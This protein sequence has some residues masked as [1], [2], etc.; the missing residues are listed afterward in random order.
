[1]Y[2]LAPFLY[3][4]RKK[5]WQQI[6]SYEYVSFFEQNDQIAPSKIFFQKNH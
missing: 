2:L 6:Q 5:I 3:K 4:I 1:M